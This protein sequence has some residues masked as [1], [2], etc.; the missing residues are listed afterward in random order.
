MLPP[1]IVQFIYL[2]AA[3]LFILGLR[4]MSLP[5]RAARGNLYAAAGMLIAVLVTLLDRE[6]VSYEAIAAGIVLGT[7]AGVALA[8]RTR[9]TEMPQLVA[10][11]NGLGGLAAVLVSGAALS[12]TLQAGNARGTEFTVAVSITGLIGAATFLGSL[13]A[14]AKLQSIVTERPVRLPAHHLWSALLLCA[15]LAAGT[16][17]V[18]RPVQSE[19]YWMVAGFSALLG[20]TMVLPIGEADMPVV[21]ALLNSC[22]GL[23]AAA[24][25]FVLRNSVLIVSGALVGS[26]GIVLT[27]IMCRGMNRSLG[28]VLFGRAKERVAAPA[29]D[30]Y[31][32]RIKATTPEEVALLLDG[33][34]R[35]V[36]V[37][38]YGMAVSQ[39]QH[40]IRDLDAAL[41]AR[42]IHVEYAI[43]P[44]AGRMPG[45]MNVLLA[46]AEIPYEK[47][48]EMADVNPTLGQVDVA[49]VIGAN[50]I[51][52]PAAQTDPHS[53]I[54]GMPIIEVGRARSVVVIKRT[55]A[56]GFAG[57][58]NPLFAADNTLMIFADGRQ[59]ALDILAALKEL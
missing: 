18:I 55:L 56:P 37:P 25:G 47:M 3:V 17:L 36:F 44:V 6:V 40:A 28:S 10:V 46:E 29:D 5:R 31:A 51:V 32:G 24:T 22:A 19:F 39:A 1:A 42:G 30:I 45:Q 26:A 27:Q 49:I 50:D 21:I 15:S 35:V 43:H 16:H 9:L 13:A 58:P 8:Q 7:G 14:F 48:R 34:R 20:L 11:L 41:E 53:P 52:N 4:A 57:I 2:F 38:G 23:A 12:E 54:A 59:A 33:A